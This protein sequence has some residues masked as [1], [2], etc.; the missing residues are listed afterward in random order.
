[1]KIYKEGD[2][3]QEQLWKVIEVFGS[4]IG[5]CKNVPF[6]DCNINIINQKG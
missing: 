1:M 3:Y 4:S 5:L 6:K 2:V